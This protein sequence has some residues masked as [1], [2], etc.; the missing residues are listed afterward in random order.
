MP[1]SAPSTLGIPGGV[2]GRFTKQVNTFPAEF[3]TPNAGTKSQAV[4]RIMIGGNL[5]LY[6]I[7]GGET[8]REEGQEQQHHQQ[9]G[10]SKVWGVGVRYGQRWRRP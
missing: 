2:A 7:Y 8:E 9:Q 3:N 5:M 6:N 4:H 10:I 1:T